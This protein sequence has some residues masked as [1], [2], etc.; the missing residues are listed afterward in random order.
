MKDR[1]KNYPVNL[2]I[3]QD[4]GEGLTPSRIDP[5]IVLDGVMGITIQVRIDSNQYYKDEVKK[6]LNE[7]FQLILEYY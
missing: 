2:T 7:A 4:I 1:E 6:A 3:K 5:Q